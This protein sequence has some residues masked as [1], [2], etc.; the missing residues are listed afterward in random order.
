MDNKMNILMLNN[1]FPP[2]G[3]G[4]GIANYHNLQEFAKI[5]N[6]SI[7]LVTAS[8]SSYEYK[9]ERFS[10]SIFIH[11]VPV[12]NKNI[13]HSSKRELLLYTFRGWRYCNQLLKKK[14]YDMSFSYSALPA[15][16]ISY[17][18]SKYQKLPYIVS[19]RGSD[20]PGFDV[21]YK[22]IYPLLTPIIKKIC[23]SADQ[24][25]TVSDNLKVMAE[26]TLPNTSIC[27]RTNGVDIDMFSP[28]IKDADKSSSFNILCVARL[29]KRKGIDRII[30]AFQRLQAIVEDPITLTIIGGG[31]DELQLKALSKKLGLSNRVVFAGVIPHADI[32]NYYSIADVFILLSD[33]E[34]MSNS[35][36]EALA[37][38][39]PLIM[40]NSIADS[41]III[42]KKNGFVVNKSDFN[43][44][45]IKIAELI[46]NPSLKIKMGIESRKMA[47]NLSWKSESQKLI[48]SCFK[49][50]EGLVIP[51]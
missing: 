16:Y 18:L 45:A 49:L 5:E 17:A 32:S 20:V 14:D 7:D 37:S 46:Q 11:K 34:G 22:Y 30:Y 51:S 13:H 48:E 8:R 12:G 36:L 15:G 43:M 33:N 39:I 50:K 31:D 47:E 6:L 4:T 35:T 2:L 27:V 21:R 28:S 26:K 41:K 25:V 1:E 38:G 10:D 3:G 23:L 42:D 44:I 29:V 9:K 19:L 24:I 40:S